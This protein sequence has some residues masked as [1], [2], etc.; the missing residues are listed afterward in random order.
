M[1]LRHGS[2]PTARDAPAGRSDA[3]H[4]LFD[5]PWWLDA[6]AP[7][8]WGEVSLEAGGAVRARLPYVIKESL[9]VTALTQPPLTPA[10][11]PWIAPSDG[12]YAKQLTRE[13]EAM[14]ELID[15]LPRFDLFAQ[16]F[17]PRVTNWL[18][19]YWSGFQATVRYTYRLDDL[20]DLDRVQAGF[21]PSLR[22]EIRKAERTL[23]VRSDLGLPAFLELNA[24]TFRRQG[25]PLPYSREVVERVDAAC[26]RHDARRV[27][28]AVDGDGRAHAALY[29]VWNRDSA[30]YL[31][32]GGDP[33]LRTSGAGSLLAW[34]AIRFCSG[35][36]R[37]FDF[38]GSLIPS[39]E[40]FFRSFG[41]RQVPYLHVR[42]ANRRGRAASGAHGLARRSIAPVARRVGTAA[43]G[44]GR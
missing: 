30:Y 20:G 7:G 36:T 32:S 38:E 29:V 11:G 6:V 12:G 41:A 26:A 21:R 40:R 16:S 5:Q 44:I 31:M 10:L 34:E 1:A 14:A 15:A 23:V 22:R 19:F 42:K 28:F 9:G 3:S 13:H 17:H 43:R 33:A 27:F 2:T 37:G 39:V 18:P 25:L 24:K 4:S 8:R 35:V